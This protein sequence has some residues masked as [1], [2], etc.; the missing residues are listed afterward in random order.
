MYDLDYSSDSNTYSAT[1][2]ATLTQ[3]ITRQFEVK[4]SVATEAAY[5]SYG[6]EVDYRPF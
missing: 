2:R 1:G 3:A 6:G 5:N 4:A